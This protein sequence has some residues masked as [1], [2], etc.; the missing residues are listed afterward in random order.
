MGL[1]HSPRIVTEDLEIFVDVANPKAYSTGTVISDLAGGEDI[2]L[3]SGANV[4]TDNNGVIE[5]D[6][7]NDYVDSVR[8]SSTALTEY[9]YSLWINFAPEALGVDHRFFWR[10]NYTFLMYKT[11]TDGLISYVR[12]DTTATGSSTGASSV[13]A[14]TWYNFASTYD[15]TNIRLYVNGALSQTTLHGSGGATIN[16]VPTRFWL[17]AASNSFFAPCKMGPVMTYNKVL[18]DSEI[19]QN[20][21]ALR[22]RFGI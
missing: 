14:D 2:S 19:Q 3:I 21:N 6:G 12:T 9:S 5:F 20:F 15:G 4:L 7:T 13:V 17:G 10:G 22:G 8:S 16:S 11:S 18:S 1:A